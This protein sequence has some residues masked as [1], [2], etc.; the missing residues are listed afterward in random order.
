M[1]N[2]DL[3]YMLSK[4][5]FLTPAEESAVWFLGSLVRVRLDASATN[6]KLAVIEH[7]GGRGYGSPVHRHLRDDETFFILD[8]ELRIEVDGTSRTAGAGSVAFLPRHLVHAFVVTSL[9]ARFLTLHTPAGF[10]EFTR[11]AGSPADPGAV[12]HP[13]GLTQPDPAA[14]KALAKTYGVDII[15][16]PPRP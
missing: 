5:A 10:D 14:L 2:L 8:G 15:G 1:T 9:E 16:P 12:S 13:S 3:R 7:R 4:P 6:G 11:A